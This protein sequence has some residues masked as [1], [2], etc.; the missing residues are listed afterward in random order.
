MRREGM[1]ALLAGMA[2]VA[3]LGAAG[4]GDVAR[5]GKSPGYLVITQMAGASGAEPTKF[6]AT[7]FSDV[8]TMVEQTVDGKQVKV[9]TVFSD[10]GRV[11]FRLELKDPGP[12]GSATTPSPLNQITVSRYRVRFVRTDGRNAQG[13]DVPYGFDGAA[14][15][16]VGGGETTTMGFDLVRHQAKEEP[17][18]K[19]LAANGGAQL[20]STI[21]EITFYGRDQAGNEVSVQGQMSV[22]F[23]DFGD[24]K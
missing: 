7:V 23:G 19:N 20:I 6:G 21:A 5:T 18:L 12:V 16:T 11:S 8:L 15:V 9:P 22:N 13:T 4:C 17:P 3:A 10:P 14:T 24:P 2:A 1:R